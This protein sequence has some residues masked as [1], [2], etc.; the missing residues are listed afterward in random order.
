MKN[1]Y[2]VSVF[3]GGKNVNS[4]YLGSLDDLPDIKFRYKECEISILDLHTFEQYP[5]EQVEKEIQ[6]A[7]MRCVRPKEK[8]SE[9]VKVEV[10]KKPKKVKPKKY[11]DR[12]V[13]CVETGE[14]FKTIKECSIKTGIPYMT[15]TNCIKNGNPTR[16]LHF[17][18]APKEKKD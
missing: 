1:N 2:F 12:P 4:Y 15:I 5:R 18:N 10:V 13:L 16:G 8:P 3:V 14:V 9:V 6:E 7:I 17:V 11:W